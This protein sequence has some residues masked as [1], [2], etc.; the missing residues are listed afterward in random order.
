MKQKPRCR[1]ARTQKNL[2]KRDIKKKRKKCYALILR[3][4]ST[5]ANKK[6]MRF[7][8]Y[9]CCHLNLVSFEPL[10]WKDLCFNFAS[11]QYLL[12]LDIFC[13]LYLLCWNLFFFFLSLKIS[14]I[15]RDIKKYIFFF[16]FLIGFI[17]ITIFQPKWTFS[18]KP[19]SFFVFV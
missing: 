16:Q 4:N 12:L 8:H 5:W 7:G 10:S 2:R 14:S 11:R 15:N 19:L 6:K 1:S 3:S 18:N 9:S 13:V 17:V